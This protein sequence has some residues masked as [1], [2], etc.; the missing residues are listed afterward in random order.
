M[1]TQPLIKIPVFII[2]LVLIHSGISMLF[3]ASLPDEIVRLDRY[4]EQGED[5]LYLGDS[6][7]LLPDGEVSTGEIL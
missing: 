5:V 7:L 6:T 1:K 4:L 3:P 2:L